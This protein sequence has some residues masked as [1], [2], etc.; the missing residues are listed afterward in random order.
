M[1]NKR[2]LGTK[3]IPREQIV[4]RPTLFQNRDEDYSKE[5]VEKIV[6]E[7]FDKSREPIEVWYDADSD[8]YVVISGHSR[9]EASKRL[10][11]AGD[12][13]LAEMPVKIFNGT[14][15][16]AISYTTLESNR[17]STSEGLKGDL[18]AYK[19]A[20]EGGCNKDCLRGIF[21][22][23]S[24]IT[25]LQD[26][27]YLNEKGQFLNALASDQYA[28]YPSLENYAR[29]TGELR[30]FYEQLTDKH[31]NEI[32]DYIYLKGGRKGLE[33]KEDFKKVIEKVVSSFTFDKN[34]PLNLAN[35]RNK[36]VYEMNAEQQ[37]SEIE[38]EIK[39]LESRNNYLDGLIAKFEERKDTKNVEKYKT[40]Y[41]R[42]NDIIR[43]KK[44]SI[45]KIQ[46]AAKQANKGAL[47]LFASEAP[48]P[49]KQSS[50]NTPVK[51]QVTPFKN[52]PKQEKAE[53]KTKLTPTDI[54]PFDADLAV[55]DVLFDEWVK[56]QKEELESE[57]L[58]SEGIERGLKD[59]YY[60]SI[61]QHI[62]N[63]GV[64]SLQVYEAL[65]YQ[66]HF[67]KHYNS[68]GNKVDKTTTTQKEPM[69]AESKKEAWEMT[70][71]E[72]SKK[73]FF[74]TTD[75]KAN[76]E[77]FEFDLTRKQLSEY[78]SIRKQFPKELDAEI[79]KKMKKPINIWIKKVMQDYHKYSVEN[80]L[81]EGKPVPEE[82]LSEYPELQPKGKEVKQ[83]NELLEIKE[84]LNDGESLN[85]QETS[86]I[87]EYAKEGVLRFMAEK[88]INVNNSGVDKAQKMQKE[89]AEYIDLN[90][91]GIISF[92]LRS[93][94][95]ARNSK[96]IQKEIDD[97]EKKRLEFGRK[98]RSSSGAYKRD[99]D[100]FSLKLSKLQSEMEEAK[101]QEGNPKATE[102]KSDTD[103]LNKKLKAVNILLEDA[104]GEEKEYLTKKKKAILILLED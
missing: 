38:K 61:E 9:W 68:R 27:Q 36:S 56:P 29:W 49:P 8:K 58:Y 84:K 25:K 12:Y 20:V 80:A 52:E 26:L 37:V 64:I 81:S 79:A 70:K 53:E 62:R 77:G 47:D 100:N 57:N 6:R 96:V 31:E 3:E 78:E 48:E 32:F 83:G 63:G 87:E 13:E 35:F 10:F 88:G 99:M 92:A 24:V 59:E 90:H 97:I 15:E 1:S 19:K 89:I 2:F 94:I 101:I 4:T 69:K 23:D 95:K 66:Q 7:G 40:E 65:P 16:E 71:K 73:T 104:E 34:K 93:L 43:T 82:V 41:N 39:D 67:D 102:P 55:W 30:R 60:E 17:L 21:K 72:W 103:Y 14:L 50:F 28:Q 85:P 75:N 54:K 86:I 44:L 76:T 22:K 45:G 74:I 18:R 5:S 42:N 46:D 98:P 51:M 11:E 33:R 91:F